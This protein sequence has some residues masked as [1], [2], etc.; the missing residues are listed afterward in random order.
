MNPYMMLLLEILISVAASMVV[1]RILTEPLLRTLERV[2]PDDQSASFW[3]TYSRV[4]LVLAPLILVLLVDSFSR[5]SNP[6]DSLRLTVLAALG[7]LLVGM[8]LL[9][10]RL[11]KFIRLPEP[12]ELSN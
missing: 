11:G 1:L 2:C 3:L 8:F 9:G 7:G 10:K 5:Y 6:L 4:M 12:A